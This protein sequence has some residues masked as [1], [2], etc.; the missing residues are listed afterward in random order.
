ML[1]VG[2]GRLITRDQDKPFME[3]GCVCIQD[4]LIAEVGTTEA[5]RKK[6]SQAEFVD[7]KGGIIMPAAMGF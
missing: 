7:A 5:L 4:Q 6:Y 3:D 1:L 2:N